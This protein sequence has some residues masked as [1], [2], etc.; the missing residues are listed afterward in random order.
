MAGPAPGRP[1]CPEMFGAVGDGV[2][3]DA[4]SLQKVFASGYT[5]ECRTEAVYR[6][7]R[8]IE[9]FDR[10]KVIGNRATIRKFSGSTTGITGRL[11]AYG[12][13]YNYDVD[14]AVVF[15]ASNDY[16]AFID[17]NDLII[18][19]EKVLGADVGYVFYSPYICT[20]TLRNITVFGGEYG[21]WG[22]DIWMVSWER[23]AA[24]SKCGFV[25]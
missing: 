2:T 16:Y 7:S 4:I 13:L 11:G 25:S 23:C 9:M 12:G 3:D 6:T 22:A 10:Q 5:V 19:K 1:V 21:F 17:I 15:A 8:P 14:C 24:Y 18:V 20:S